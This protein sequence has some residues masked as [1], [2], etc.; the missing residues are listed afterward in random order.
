MFWGKLYF[1]FFYI[2]EFNENFWYI[3]GNSKKIQEFLRILNVQC[4][5][6]ISKMIVASQQINYVNVILQTITVINIFLNTWTVYDKFL[7]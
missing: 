5:S 2:K 3:F 7:K 4:L 6:L 1:F